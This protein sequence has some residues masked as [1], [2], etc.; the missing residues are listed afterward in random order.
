MQSEATDS[1]A[2]PD[3]LNPD[4][5][6]REGARRMLAAALQVE[7]AEYITQHRKNLSRMTGHGDDEFGRRIQREILLRRRGRSGVTPVDS[8]VADLDDGF[9]Q[10]FHCSPV[11]DRGCLGADS[12]QTGPTQITRPCNGSTCAPYA[13]AQTQEA[14]SRR[15]PEGQREGCCR[16]PESATDQQGQCRGFRPASL[17]A[18]I[19]RRFS[20]HILPPHRLTHSEIP[21]HPP[22]QELP[23]VSRRK[24]EARPDDA[25]V[26]RR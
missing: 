15:Y 25:K 12:A 26:L 6:A 1:A 4:T 5:L 13:G 8:V 21:V 2:E 10:S 16:S 23:Q 14:S 17:S 24:P 18:G 7:L 22:P 9:L 11:A 3:G 20:A 19:T